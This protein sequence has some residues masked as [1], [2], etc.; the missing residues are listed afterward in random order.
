MPAS[1]SFIDMT[2]RTH[3]LPPS[4]SLDISTFSRL[5]DDTTNSYKFVFFLSLL[6]ILSNSSFD[7]SSPISLN[8]LAVEMLVNAWYPHSVFRLSFGLQ[9]MIARKLDELT[10]HIN[11]PAFKITENNK[12]IRC[13]DTFSC[14]ASIRLT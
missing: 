7:V 8:D 4:D 10:L 1:T 13:R 3:S 6:N 12:L 2:E 5:L 11:Q 14:P 9:D